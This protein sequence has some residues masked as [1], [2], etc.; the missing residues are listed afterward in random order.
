MALT[1]KQQRFVEEYLVD[2]NATQ[3]AIRAGYAPKNADKQGSQLLG[4]PRVSEAIQEAMKKRSKRT[5]ITQDKV[6]NEIASNAFQVASDLSESELK[7]SSKAKYLDMLC[8]CLGMYE[9]KENEEDSEVQIID[10]Y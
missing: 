5:E 9:K 1:P 2:L 7:H 4:K 10:D 3:A 6:L 8:K